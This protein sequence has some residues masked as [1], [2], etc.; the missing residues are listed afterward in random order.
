[1]NTP[2][3]FQLPLPASRASVATAY[4]FVLPDENGWS[5]ALHFEAAWLLLCTGM[6]YLFWGLLKGHFRRLHPGSIAG[7]RESLR[8]H[9]HPASLSGNAPGQYNP[10]Q[11]LVYLAV[12]FLL[13]PFVIWTGLAMSPAFTAAL[14]AS[15]T[16]LGGV[17][18][19]RTLHFF[20]S[21]AVVLFVLA[22]VLMVALAGFRVRM[23]AMLVGNPGGN[24]KDL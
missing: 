7:L 6:V 3:L 9:W 23:R 8:A 5:R 13:F 14:P 11:R 18:S 17:Q 20:A 2:A 12:I 16:L 22:H 1:M 4:S 21:L 19:A 24:G 10:L 15:V